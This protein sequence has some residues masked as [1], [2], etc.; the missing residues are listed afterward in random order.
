M[1]FDTANSSAGQLELAE[2]IWYG[3]ADA[4]ICWAERGAVGRWAGLREHGARAA[5]RFS[6]EKGG[7]RV[8]ARELEDVTTSCVGARADGFPVADHHRNHNAQENPLPPS[9]GQAYH[10]DI[11]RHRSDGDRLR[12]GQH[13]GNCDSACD[14]AQTRWA[15]GIAGRA[16]RRWRILRR[17]SSMLRGETRGFLGRGEAE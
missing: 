10:L 9:R 16:R 14:P 13:F 1:P 11:G 17:A 3:R 2:H 15:R 4:V 6:C 8:L 12:G 7:Q 5:R